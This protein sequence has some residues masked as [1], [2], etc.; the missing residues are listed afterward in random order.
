MDMLYAC[1]MGR[2]LALLVTFL[3]ATLPLSAVASHGDHGFS[4][5][6]SFPD[7]EFIT[8]DSV[9]GDPF[10]AGSDITVTYTLTGTFT[11]G[12][13]FTVELSDASG[14]F[15]SPTVIGS[16]TDTFATPIVCTLPNNLSTGTS[17]RVR[18]NSSNPSSLGSA[19]PNTFTIYALPAQPT[20]TAS[21][22]IQFCA[23][24][25]VTL[26]SNATS[27]NTW[28]NGATTQDIVVTASGTF[29]VEVT[30][31]GC[32]SPASD[33][34]TV[35]VRNNPPTPIITPLGPTTFCQGDSVQLT[36]NVPFGM[37]WQPGNMQT[38]TVTVFTGANYTVSRTNIFG[39]TSVSAPLTVTVNPLPPTPTVSPVGPV[40]LCI[41]QTV[42]LTSS[43]ATG[44]NWNVGPTTQ[45]IVVDSTWDYWTIVIDA[46]GCVS[47]TSN[48]VP[49]VVDPVPPAPTIT[50][51]G[52]TS[53]CSGDSVI[54]TSSA[55]V[56]NV[57]STGET[58]QSITV[59]ASGDYW[60]LV[61][62]QT[63]VSDTSAF[64]TVSVTQMPDTPS[65]SPIGPFQFC[66]GGSVTLTSSS[67]VG[68]QWSTGAT[69]QSIVVTT[70]GSYY[71]EVVDGI[72]VSEPSNMVTVSLSPAPPTPVITPLGPTTFC[73]GESVDLT[74]NVPFG[75][76]WHPTNQNT[77]TISVSTAGTYT[78]SR[79][80]IFG[81]TSTSAP[82]T[83]TVNPKPQTP[84]I[85]PAGPIAICSPDSVTLT[86]S[87]SA[88][89]S[90]ANGSLDQS[91]TVSTSGTHW[92][93]VTNANGCVSDTSNVVEV[94]LNSTPATPTITASG[95]LTFCSGDS[96]IL[97]SSATNGN[98]WSTGET[99]Q[100]IT[101]FAS[102]DYWVLVNDGLC[103]SDT[104]NIITVSV[105]QMPSAPS[106][107]PA[108]PFQFCAG[109]SVTLTSSSPV[110]NLWSTGA[111]THSI[112]VTTAGSYSVQTVNGF[113][114]SPQSN[115]V[116]VSISPTPPT[117]VITP[118]GPTTFCD[119]E[120]VD[121]TCNVLFGM[122]WHPT[123]QNT[124]TITVT[125]A[126]TYTVSRTNIF[127][128]TS[129]SAPVTV[130]VNPLPTTP[131]ISPAGPVAL[132]TPDSVTL[133]SSASSGNIWSTGATTQS[134]TV[135]T[136][137]NYFVQ[138]TDA[139][140]C[141]SDTSNVVEVNMNG[142]PATPTIT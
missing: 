123:N 43:A 86:S 81:C 74:C 116:N 36:C 60:V 57:W 79:T 138:T 115:V 118:L 45:S 95:S 98:F 28:S 52:P 83:V 23:G 127:G 117:P 141:T 40:P 22:P 78:V 84:V 31:N 72:C 125:T 110:D 20:I 121:L 68:N 85:S 120:S 64:V 15:S 65:V 106:V 69:T 1:R 101:V 48:S 32:I 39:C 136:A 99:T 71:V 96:V 67:P 77:Q 119:G 33:P 128:C 8:T 73:D 91:I 3:M 27:G 12:N 62:N 124:Q 76:T 70:A 59:F 19:S 55:S 61:D 41:G 82:V 21:G 18:V 131:T 44:N 133:T 26:S 5:D 16:I 11:I 35:V 97:T 50:A 37:V 9:F 47:D 126:G 132:C 107:S 94:T 38:Q 30:E 88:G 49:V 56:D 135:S 93:L 142:T 109:G 29:T 75:M 134:I 137:G 90:W 34:V 103:Q 105:T 111:T 6:R 53:F 108:G 122:T 54:L 140:G 80:N 102:G 92:V 139:N 89:N 114:V 2:G 7:G 130:T 42:E 24:G 129:T 113:C 25:S 4:S 13:V 10:C 104:S 63:C 87:E 14:S 66:P 17:Y 100:S 51:S 112:V 46:N 58:T